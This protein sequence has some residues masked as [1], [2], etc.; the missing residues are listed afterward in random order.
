MK[1][2]NDRTQLGEPRPAKAPSRKRFRIEKLE[3]R[4]APAK[5]GHLNPKSK[6]VGS[7]NG[8]GPCGF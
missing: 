5:G 3:A 2:M 7:T 4:I 1:P 8:P 6:W